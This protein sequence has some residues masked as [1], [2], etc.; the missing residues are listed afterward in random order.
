[1][2]K[3][4]PDIEL[5]F[6]IDSFKEDLSA[7]P[8]IYSPDR[9]STEVDAIIIA[10]SF[11]RD[12]L[13]QIE[14]ESIFNNIALYSTYGNLD[15]NCSESTPKRQTSPE[16]YSDFKNGIIR[17]RTTGRCNARCRFCNFGKNLDRKTYMQNEMD[18]KWMYEYFRPLYDKSKI[19][20]LSSGETILGR[21]AME[22]FRFL[23]TEYPQATIKCES[24]GIAFTPKWQQ[25]CAENMVMMHFSLN[26]V[27]EDTFLKGV[28]LKGAK[29]G[30][31]A[32][33]RSQQNVRDYISLLQSQGI[34]VFAPSISMVV[35]E[36][37]YADVQEFVRMALDMKAA[38][39]NYFFDYS[40]NDIHSHNFEGT[41]AEDVLIELM[42]IER[43]LKDRFMVNFRLYLPL[44]ILESNQKT[45]DIIPIEMLKEEYE[46]LDKMADGRSVREEYRERE[47]IRKQKGKTSFSF[48]EDIQTTL[49]EMHVGGKKIC[50]PPWKQI[51]IFPNGNISFCGWREAVLNIN[52]FIKNDAVD[53]DE[54]INSPKFVMHRK[55]MLEGDYDG[56]MRCC[57]LNPNYKPINTNVEHSVTL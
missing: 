6:L 43:V 46:E 29:G 55:E 17:V 50:F 16:L 57:P 52:D 26:A 12:I 32:Y 54:I 3:R 53:W 21:K 37:T 25:L 14:N 33:R 56:C 39:V 15:Q 23:S 41:Y 49:W 44:G 24:N 38:S 10:S 28:W 36:D 22:Y 1:M 51:D 30:S 13:K 19:I 34:G 18:P 47:R 8:P 48:L 45:V 27:H 20:I 35:N 2:R 7:K 11:Y 42:K 9:V 4:R 40:E 31:K 5:L